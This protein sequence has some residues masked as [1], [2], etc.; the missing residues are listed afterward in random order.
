MSSVLYDITA[1]K[2]ALENAI[3]G[4]YDNSLTEYHG[5]DDMEFIDKVYDVTGISREDYAE[6]ML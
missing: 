2:T 1:L 5:L 3:I 4:W 6:I